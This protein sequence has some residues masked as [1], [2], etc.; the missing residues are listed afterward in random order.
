MPL[1]NGQ[2]DTSFFTPSGCG[3]QF[4]WL[5][6]NPTRATNLGGACIFYQRL[7]FR[8]YPTRV[9]NLG[10]GPLRVGGLDVW[11]LPDKLPSK[12]KFA[13]GFLQYHAD[14]V[15]CRAL[16]RTPSRRIPWHLRILLHL[17]HASLSAL[18]RRCFAAPQRSGRHAA[19]HAKRLRPPVSMAPMSQGRITGEWGAG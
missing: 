6:D 18:G 14:F 13:N 5:T 8:D 17:C 9:T 1:L 15:L 19:F 11:A 10:G 3:R 7:P 16:A 2:G 4:H 12:R